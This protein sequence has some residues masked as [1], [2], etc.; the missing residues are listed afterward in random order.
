MT[1]SLPVSS[2]LTGVED[3]APGG[4]DDPQALR[5]R[6]SVGTSAGPGVGAG[7]FGSGREMEWWVSASARHRG[8]QGVGGWAGW[9]TLGGRGAGQDGTQ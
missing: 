8:C 3:G 4:K 7:R 1:S 5:W 2:L 9:L 6:G